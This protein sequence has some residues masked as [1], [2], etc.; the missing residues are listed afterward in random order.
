MEETEF[1]LEPE[2]EA[3]DNDV[4]WLGIADDLEAYF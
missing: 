4:D 3:D 1:G 2:Q